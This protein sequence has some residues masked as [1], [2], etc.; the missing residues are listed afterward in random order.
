MLDF[1]M[2][3]V[4]NPS[5]SLAVPNMCHPVECK[6][7]PIKTMPHQSL[8]SNNPKRELEYDVMSL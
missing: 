2:S 7:E 4:Q 5:S 1:F 8:H 6:C 3:F